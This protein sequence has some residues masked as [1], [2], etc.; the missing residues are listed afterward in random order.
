LRRNGR[1][2]CGQQESIIASWVRTEYAGAGDGIQRTKPAK[3]AMQ[4]TN[5]SDPNPAALF[6]RRE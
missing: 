3:K 4:R 5:T 2:T 6:P 1:R